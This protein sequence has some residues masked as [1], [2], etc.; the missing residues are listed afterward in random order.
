LYLPQ[1][2]CSCLE[3]IHR[4]T[5]QSKQLQPISPS[6]L[7]TPTPADGCYR[8]AVSDT[9]LPAYRRSY[10]AAVVKANAWIIY[11]G[12]IADNGVHI[13][14]GHQNYNQ[15]TFCG[16][17]IDENGKQAWQLRSGQ[18]SGNDLMASVAGDVLLFRLDPRLSQLTVV[19]SRTRN[20]TVIEMARDDEPDKPLYISVN[21]KAS[22]SVGPLT[23]VELRQMTAAE[24]AMLE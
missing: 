22:S 24:R 23:Q 17:G 7:A 16:V 13:S 14:S 10:W 18:S 6:E 4:S 1:E 15:S 19:N 20:M 2:S 11:V 3:L 8:Y 21:L 12:V 9:P 5:Y